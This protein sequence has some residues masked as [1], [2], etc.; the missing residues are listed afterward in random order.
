MPLFAFQRQGLRTQGKWGFITFFLAIGLG[1]IFIEISFVQ[2]F[3]LF[4]GYPTYSLTVVLFSLLTYSAVG[5]ALAARMQRPP[6]QRL[7]P[8]AAALAALAPRYVVALTT[9]LP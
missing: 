3:V 2:K 6:E 5:S 9:L 7:L 4:L 8:L 1:Y